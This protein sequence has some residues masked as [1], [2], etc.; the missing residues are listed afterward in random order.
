MEITLCV[1]LGY[2]SLS[3]LSFFN[4]CILELIKNKFSLVLL[5]PD[6][7]KPSQQRIHS[8]APGTIVFEDG[9]VEFYRPDVA[10]VRE[11]IKVMT[12]MEANTARY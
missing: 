9:S 11:F 4:W 5:F 6:R 2:I 3:F 7:E 12:F 1:I 10:E 8:Y